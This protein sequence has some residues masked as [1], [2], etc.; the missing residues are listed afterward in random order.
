MNRSTR[1]PALALA[2][3]LLLAGSSSVS[4][5]ARAAS[6]PVGLDGQF[7]TNLSAPVL[8]P[9][10]S[11]QVELRLGDPLVGPLVN[12]TVS[13]GFYAYVAAL[14]AA[15]ELGAFPAVGFA[16]G[17]NGALTAT[18]QTQYASLGSGA[19][20]TASVPVGSTSG[21]STGSYLVRSSLTFSSN[22]TAYRFASVGWFPGPLWARA[23]NRSEN[24][25]VDL[26]LSM[27]GVDGVSAETAVAVA[28][29]GYAAPIYLL[30][31]GGLLLAGLGAFVY[32]RKGDGSTAGAAGPPAPQSAPNAFGKNRTS[33]GERSRS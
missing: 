7:L 16:T 14:G 26:N 17:P 23:S 8:G 5:A 15:P 20:V 31:A 27:L 9:G 11:G 24:G 6:I 18:W 21:A 29:N 25:G 13:L 22:G 2:L 3:M 30:A 4:G 33:E 12:L 10:A 32:Y 28:Q 19:S 1:A